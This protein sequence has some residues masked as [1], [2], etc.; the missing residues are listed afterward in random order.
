MAKLFEHSETVP[1]CRVPFNSNLD[2]D[3]NILLLGKTGVGKTTFINAFANCLSY[4][5]LDVAL[6]GKMQILVQGGQK[7]KL[8]PF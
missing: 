5:T 3:I 6:Q 1:Q 8:T 4:D 7:Q 2:N